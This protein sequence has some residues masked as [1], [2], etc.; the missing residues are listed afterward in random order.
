MVLEK[1]FKSIREYP[2]PKT[3]KKMRGWIGLL[4]SMSNHTKEIAKPMEPLKHH[5]CVTKDN[6]RKSLKWSEE[7]SRKFTECKEKVIE[8]KV[9][10]IFWDLRF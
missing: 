5:I 10:R 9:K 7:E 3:V 2:E 1:Y 4:N 8:G 6:K